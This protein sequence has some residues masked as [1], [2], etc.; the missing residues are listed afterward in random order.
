MTAG[1]H[2]EWDNYAELGLLTTRERFPCL[3]APNWLSNNV[4]FVVSPVSVR[5][6]WAVVS[7]GSFS[8]TDW[9]GEKQQTVLD[10]QRK[11]P[12]APPSRCRRSYDEVKTH[13]LVHGEVPAHCVLVSQKESGSSLRSL[14]FL[15]IFIRI[16]F[17]TTGSPY[18]AQTSFEL[19]TSGPSLW[20]AGI[21]D[22][23]CNIYTGCPR[24]SLVIAIICHEGLT[25]T[26]IM[27]LPKRH[28]Q[29]PHTMLSI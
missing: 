22:L 2:L 11:H 14:L 12:P 19:S 9:Q 1:K 25:L 24:F 10:A 26:T 6:T 17:F 16:Y 7:P 28:F 3:P 21:T 8:T 13:F 15:F 18:L 29:L 23:H 5:H 4:T 20:S 27:T